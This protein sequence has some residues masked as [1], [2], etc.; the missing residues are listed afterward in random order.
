MRAL[1]ALC[2]LAL[3]ACAAEDPAVVAEQNWTRCAA[4]GDANERL[5]ACTALVDA[6]ATAAE[7]R[8]AALLRRGETRLELGQ[9]VRA[10]ADFGLV[11][12]LEP[13]NAEALFKRGMAHY[14][15][16]AYTAAARD[17]D[18]VLAIQPTHAEAL[19]WRANVTDDLAANFDDELATLFDLIEQ[20]PDNAGLHNNRCWLRVTNGRELDEA[21]ADCNEALRLEPNNEATLDS[22][23]LVYYKLGN[24]DASLADYDAA[25][26]ISADRGHYLFGR[27]LALQALGRAEEAQAAFE[28]AERNEPGI[29]ELYRSY[30][31]PRA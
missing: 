17:F 10:I 12:R 5:I 22:R 18:A 6:P 21:L 19:H 15:R 14:D 28:A 13:Q 2:V 31:A 27:G 9:Y 20:S 23:G 25:L 30:G 3:V 26:A 4:R 8:A 7:R 16:S 11:L 29:G 24:F 1:V